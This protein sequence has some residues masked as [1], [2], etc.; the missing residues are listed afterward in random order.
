[1]LL[2]AATAT[3]LLLPMTK[4]SKVYFGFKP[5]VWAFV[6]SMVFLTVLVRDLRESSEFPVTSRG[7]T[8]DFVVVWTSKLIVFTSTPFFTSASVMTSMNLERSCFT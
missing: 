6:V 2:A 8:L 4:L 7:R 3:S 5:L 1:M